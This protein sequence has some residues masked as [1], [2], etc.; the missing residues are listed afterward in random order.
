MIID[1]ILVHVRLLVEIIQ[2][3]LSLFLAVLRIVFLQHHG[4]D[5]LN[6]H[7]FQVDVE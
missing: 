3:C 7:I 1:V 4:L 6:W 5:K 2:P